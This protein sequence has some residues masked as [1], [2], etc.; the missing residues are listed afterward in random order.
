MDKAK[1]RGGSAE[2]SS[3]HAR[4]AVLV[5]AVFAAFVTIYRARS[6]DLIRLATNGTGVLPAGAKFRTILPGGLRGEA[7]KVAD[8]VLNM[9][10]RALDYC[11]P[12]D[13]TFGDYLRAIIT[14]D[15]DLVP[16]DDRGYRVAFISAFRDRGIFPTNVAHLAEDS[17]VWE[18]PPLSPDHQKALQPSGRDPQPAMEL[19]L[20][21]TS[22]LQQLACKCQDRP[23]LADSARAAN[24][25]PGHGLRAGKQESQASLRA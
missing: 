1:P 2:R 14:A 12:V 22:R 3:P 5:S 11:P 20:G 10:I 24:A 25:A 7:A 4:G 23:R 15:R 9:C 18:T 6:A 13:V 16:L 19:E 17:L 8:Q 21:P